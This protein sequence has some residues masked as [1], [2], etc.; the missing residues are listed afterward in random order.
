[1]SKCE[2]CGAHEHDHE[3]EEEEENLKAEIIKL[4]ISLIIFAIFILKSS[5]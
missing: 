5:K 4:V 2:H 3:H 1:M